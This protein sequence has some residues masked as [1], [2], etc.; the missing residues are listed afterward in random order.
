MKKTLLFHQ[1][2]ARTDKKNNQL[3]Q[4]RIKL[5]VWAETEQ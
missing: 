4:N 3:K 2:L 1:S 5:S